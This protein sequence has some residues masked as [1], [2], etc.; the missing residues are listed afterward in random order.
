MYGMVSGTSKAQ[1]KLL[2]LLLYELEAE[3]VLSE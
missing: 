1:G 2:P 3:V